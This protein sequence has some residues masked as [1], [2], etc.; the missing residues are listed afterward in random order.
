M[1]N[2][3]TLAMIVILLMVLLTLAGCRTTRSS[4]KTS[5][6]QNVVSVL[7]S[8]SIGTTQKNTS[9]KAVATTTESERQNVSVN[10]EEW[11]YYPSSRDTVIKA[12][13]EEAKPPNNG[14]KAYRKGTITV[15]A[16]KEV[17]R[18][19]RQ[20][21]QTQEYEESKSNVQADVKAMSDTKEESSSKK[22]SDLWFLAGVICA[23]IFV[24][25]GIYIAK[26]LL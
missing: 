16:E 3:K 9:D 17:Q 19:E 23:M 20:V 24:G 11:V 22:K 21:T 5:T 4:I 12:T 26:K 7:V 18:D 10:F 6:K 2:K 25:F 14:I 13:A 1:M 8:D 15:N